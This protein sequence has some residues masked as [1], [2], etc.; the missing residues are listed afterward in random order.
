MNPS[1]YAVVEN[2]IVTNLVLW[3]GQDNWS[4][5]SG[6]EVVSVDADDISIGWLYD[7]KTFSPP[8]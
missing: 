4:A 3:N 2:G 7:G 1:T 5:P 8:A 6:S